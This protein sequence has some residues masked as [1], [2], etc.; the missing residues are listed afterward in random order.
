MGYL[1][2]KLRNTKYYKLKK[3]PKN[4]KVDI[5]HKINKETEV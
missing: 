5:T 3:I 2:G 1:Y 4:D